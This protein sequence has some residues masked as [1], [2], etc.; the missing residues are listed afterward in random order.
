MMLYIMQRLNYTLNFY[1]HYRNRHHRRI[2]VLIGITSK[3]FIAY[4]EKK[5]NPMH[6]N[7]TKYQLKVI[8]HRGS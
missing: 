3:E 8:F 7:E 5:T 4:T 1:H 2:I 6:E